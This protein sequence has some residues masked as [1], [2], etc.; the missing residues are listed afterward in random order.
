MEA[1]VSAFAAKGYGGASTKEIAEAA[2]TSETSIYRHFGSKAELF[3]A[4]VAEPFCDFLDTYRDTFSAQVDAPWD[5]GRL[6]RA[7]LGEFYDHLRERR[8]AVRAL[9]VSTG[10][11]EAA[12]PVAAVTGRLNAVFAALEGL[13]VERA[14]KV[15][16]FSPERA[17]VWLRLLAGMV[18]S[19]AVL[20]PWFVPPGWERRPDELIGVM[21]DM[22]LYGVLKAEPT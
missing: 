5:N 14:G 17:D 2:G 15:G 16:G 18:T 9:L 22:V 19:V 8:E 20:D 6:M 10:S 12:E 11:P 1:A 13:A 3:T 4:S 7:F 21:A